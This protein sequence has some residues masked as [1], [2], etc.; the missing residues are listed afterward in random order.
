MGASKSP[1]SVTSTFF[2]TVNLL[3]KKLRF[4]YGDAKLA[5]CPG[6]YRTKLRPL[7]LSSSVVIA[8][9]SNSD[10]SLS[11][12]TC[13]S[14]VQITKQCLLFLK[15]SPTTHQFQRTAIPIFNVALVD[16]PGDWVRKHCP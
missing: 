2:N 7:Y 4:K 16:C 3:P 6:R 12:C 14:F 9:H 5:S 8:V 11:S 13:F 10:S 15:T 1:N